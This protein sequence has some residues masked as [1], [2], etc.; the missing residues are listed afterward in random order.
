MTENVNSAKQDDIPQPVRVTT[1]GEDA[2]EIAYDPAMTVADYLSRA[3]VS[4]NGSS[5]V[6]VN[7]V[8]V[9]NLGAS[10][11]PGSVIVVAGKVSNG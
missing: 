9:K 5:A 3:E 7:D 6:T 4:V 2:R 10:V 11:E 1:Y 8:T